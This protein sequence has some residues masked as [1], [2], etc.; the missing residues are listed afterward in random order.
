[1][2]KKRLI[3]SSTA[4]VIV[5][6][7]ESSALLDQKAAE[8]RRSESIHGISRGVQ[9]I[10]S[11]TA[12]VIALPLSH[13]LGVTISAQVLAGQ[14]A[15]L[16]LK[17]LYEEKTQRSAIRNHDL[18]DQWTKLPTNV[19]QMVQERYELRI[20][21][22]MPLNQPKWTRLSELLVSCRRYAI[23]WRYVTEDDPQ[24]YL[25]TSPVL[26]REAVCSVMSVLGYN[27]NWSQND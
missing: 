11:F 9:T 2:S 19:R 12:E 10:G 15:E 24:R 4:C 20:K 25:D 6:M 5:G 22:H 8:M 18:Y 23:D 1:M 17:L 7:L 26:L 3:P 13:S 27:I 21:R 16:G 14:A